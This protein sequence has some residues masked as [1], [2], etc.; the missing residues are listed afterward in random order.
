LSFDNDSQSWVIIAAPTAFPTLDY[1]KDATICLKNKGKQSLSGAAE[2]LTIQ[3]LN[4]SS[5]CSGFCFA[6][7]S[8]P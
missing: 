6:I 4:F 8:A 2:P 3:T 7:S 1:G 5:T